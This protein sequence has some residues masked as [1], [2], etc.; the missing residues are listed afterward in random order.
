MTSARRSRLPGA[1]R[2]RSRATEM[3]KGGFAT[4]RKGRRGNRTSAPSVSTTVTLSLANSRRRSLA[5]AGCNSKAMTRAPRRTSGRVN[6]PLPAPISRT[7]SPDV[8][9]A[10]SMSRSAQ[11]LSSRCHPHRVRFSD[12]ADH[13]EHCHPTT[14]RQDLMSI[15]PSNSEVPELRFASGASRLCFHRAEIAPIHLV[16]GEFG[17]GDRLRRTFWWH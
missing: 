4:T 5:R 2:R 14:I 8:I 13:R 12:T 1:V 10:F 6:A 11:R 3:L 15:S 16:G 17:L 9:P 7:R